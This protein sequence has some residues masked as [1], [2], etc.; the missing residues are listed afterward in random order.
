MN[1][2]KKTYRTCFLVTGLIILLAFES[3]AQELHHRNKD[4]PCLNKQFNIFAHMIYNKSQ[5]VNTRKL[6]KAIDLA[7]KYFAPIC[8]S[9]KVCDMDTIFNYNYANLLFGR[10]LKE[11]AIL[12]GAKNRIN[13]YIGWNGAVMEPYRFSYSTG[14]IDSIDNVHIYIGK[15]EG[16]VHELGHFF[17]LKDTFRGSGKELVDGSNCETEGDLICDTPADPYRPYVDLDTFL[18]GCVYDYYRVDAN[19]DKYQPDVGNIMSNYINCQC[20]FSY[21]QYLKMVENY[22]KAKVKHW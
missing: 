18:L 12:Y 20:G 15:E 2:I 19:G 3:N 13:L 7:N 22:R 11:M 5:K 8:V 16:L 10:D 14:T 1:I 21:Q 9:F 4:L 17:G 6:Y